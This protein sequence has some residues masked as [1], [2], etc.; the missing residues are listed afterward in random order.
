MLA[1]AP[2]GC[3]TAGTKV[4]AFRGEF[5]AVE[6]VRVGDVL[7]GPDSTPRV[8]LAL[9]GGFD[10]L[11]KVNALR[12]KSFIVNASHVLTLVKSRGKS[13]G[14][15]WT[16]AY[17]MSQGSVTDISVSDYLASS[18][19]WRSK[20]KL[21]GVGVDFCSQSPLPIKPYFLGL[22]LGDGSIKRQ[23]GITTEDPEVIDAIG[24]L[25]YEYG[26][27]VSKRVKNSGNNKAAT[28]DLASP[29]NGKKTNK[30]PLTKVLRDI[31][32]YGRGSGDKFIPL[33]YKTAS[34]NDRMEI[35]AGLIDT[36]GSLDNGNYDFIS[37][38]RRLAEDVAF[39][40]R[41]LG[42]RVKFGECQKSAHADHVGTYYRLSIVGDCC[43]IPVRIARKKAGP[44]LMNKDHQ[45]SGFALEPIGYGNVFGFTLSGDGRYLLE[46]F[47]VT[48]NSGKSRMMMDLAAD[49]VYRGG[50][51]LI[52]VHRSMLLE[53]MV[54]VFENAGNDVGVIAPSYPPNP[55]AAIQIAMS[56]TLYSRTV[57]RSSL[58]FPDVTLV[59]NDEAHQQTGVTERAMA[60]GAFGDGFSQLGYLSRGVDLIG[61]TA[62]PV[63]SQRIYSHLVQVVNYSQLRDEGMH[64]PLTMFGPDEIDTTGLKVNEAGDFK[65]ADL[66]PRV[67]EIFGS[68]FDEYEL[69]NPDRA[70]AILFAPSV[71]CSKW[72][73]YQFNTR[74]VSSAH[75][76]SDGI[77]VGDGFKP[78]RV[79]AA[80]RENR[81]S[82]LD[83]SKSGEIKIVCNRFVLREAID[84]PWMY[85][86]IFA[87]VMGSSI[88]ALQ[89]VGRLQ[90]SH[91]SYSFKIIQDHGGF[92]WRHGDPNS[93]RHWRLGLTDKAVKQERI[94]RIA[95]G[96]ES[97]GIRC[98]KCGQWRQSGGIC[99]NSACNHTH[100]QSVRRVRMLNGKL[101]EITGSV[102]QASLDKK[103]S[104]KIW[105]S[106]LYAGARSGKPVSS[107]YAMA[108]KRAVDTGNIIDWR[109]VH[110]QPPK[111]DSA[112]WHRLA[113]HVYPWLLAKRK[114]KK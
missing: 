35:L 29:S 27:R 58:E 97:E 45:R 92:W 112:D 84:M 7:M 31:G 1:V 9:C 20:Q 22:L 54:Q 83:A 24:D 16:S 76:G 71:E 109:S 23:P 102:I 101:K 48:H 77:V 110:P 63:M 86:G 67:K 111:F 55:S 69:L 61:F 30:N 39:V 70:P 57:L 19:Y 5:I 78:P 38:S 80:T 104:T 91:P 26:L 41:S 40:A 64:L 62:T 75:I 3:H 34:L 13:V 72:F 89:S 73:V 107:C 113:S 25:A 56:Q 74:G 17:E 79:I 66:T 59:V 85:H 49:E 99:L 81:Q 93:D 65:E 2:P 68:V 98:P 60:F 46:D 105:M 103:K 82:I 88:T 43:R 33:E 36:D 32:V 11:Y 106:C 42:F 114:S 87:T 4:L 96:Q 14:T 47:T 95:N 94:E 6:D 8:V 50:R 10:K 44:R 100:S 12:R 108:E 51:A 18:A 37:K 53:Q 21:F 28:Y 52:K 15:R 90:R